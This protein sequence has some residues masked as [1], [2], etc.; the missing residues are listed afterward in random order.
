MDDRGELVNGGGAGEHPVADAQPSSFLGWFPGVSQN[1]DLPPPPVAALG[2]PARL[3]SDF[4]AL[5]QGVPTTGCA[6]EST[7]ESWYRF[8]VQPDPYDQVLVRGGQASLA[9]IDATILRQRREF[10]RPESR[11]VVLV[12][13]DENDASIDPMAPRSTA[14]ASRAFPGS[15]TGAAPAG[16]MECAQP[17][18]PACTSCSLLVDDPTFGARCPRGAFLPPAEDPPALRFFDMKRRFG[19]DVL[20]PIARYVRGLAKKS[21]PD[22]A[23][24]HDANGAYSDAYAT[25]SATCVNPLFARDLPSDPGQDLC[26]LPLGPRRPDQIQFGV[27]GGVPHQLLAAEPANPEGPPK[28]ALTTADWTAILG[29][30]AGIGQDAHMIE[31]TTPR[32]GLALPTAADD[33]DPIHG[34]EWDTKGGSLELACTFPLAT[35]VG[36]TPSEL[37][38]GCDCG[39]GGDMPVCDPSGATQTRGKAYPSLR[40]LRVAAALRDGAAV[41]SICPIHPREEAAGDPLYGFRPLA[42]RLFS[43]L[44]T[45]PVVECLPRPLT[46]AADGRVSCRMLVWLANPAD[47]TLCTRVGL[48]APDAETLLRYHEAGR[49]LCVVPQLLAADLDPGSVCT[50]SKLGWCYAVLPN[51]CPTLLLSQ[52]S[53]DARFLITCEEGC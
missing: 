44:E 29:G 19:A 48:Q 16:S 23:H 8:L 2:D 6:L 9:G 46:R 15:P 35:P 4:G 49:P 36:C 24:E 10:L 21:V 32:P 5:L 51:V 52:P 30:S 25:A 28:D 22:R 42:K 20:F 27:V 34:R 18:D 53:P 41:A 7:L 37:A 39:T 40:P 45:D 14:F 47:E 12:V 31:S 43:R 17:D 33:T 38:A 1:I 26:H 50:S 3:L 11:L 13:T